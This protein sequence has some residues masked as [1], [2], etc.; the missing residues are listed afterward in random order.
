MKVQQRTTQNRKAGRSKRCALRRENRREEE[1]GERDGRK[2]DGSAHADATLHGDAHRRR[3]HRE[4]PIES[5]APPKESN[6]SVT[7]Q[8]VGEHL[9][10]NTYM[11]FSASDN[12][13]NF[14]RVGITCHCSPLIHLIP[15]R[16]PSPYPTISNQKVLQISRSLE[17]GP[18][19]SHVKGMPS[20]IVLSSRRRV[21]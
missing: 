1:A 18:L 15:S 17:E 16:T 2:S 14:K 3:A 9:T 12:K 6:Y 8:L 11:V 13:S 5:V 21:Q 20:S 19:A 7:G 10:T 4:S